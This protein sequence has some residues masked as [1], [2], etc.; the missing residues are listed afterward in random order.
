MV[1]LQPNGNYD[2]TLTCQWGN[3]DVVLVNCGSTS[4]EGKTSISRPGFFN[5]TSVC[6]GA[7]LSF[8]FGPE[9]PGECYSGF[10]IGNAHD[11]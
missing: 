10:G 8:E 7:V 2:C 5:P 4:S 9:T 6:A 11:Q 3:G 1:G